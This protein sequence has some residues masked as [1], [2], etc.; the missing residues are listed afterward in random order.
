[1]KAADLIKKQYA[2]K[3]QKTEYQFVHY[4]KFDYNLLK[5]IW[6]QRTRGVGE[7]ASYNDVIIMADTETSKKKP[8]ILD[9]TAKKEKW[10]TG[11]NHVVAW[12]I[13]IRAYHHNIVTLYGRKPSKMIETLQRIHDHMKGDRGQI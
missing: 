7:R 2:E 5:Y 6:Y 4:K 8:D 10:T 13:S 3:I 9:P 1:M 12:T 11:E